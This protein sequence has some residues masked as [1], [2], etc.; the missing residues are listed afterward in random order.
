[1][2]RKSTARKTIAKRQANVAPKG[3]AQPAARPQKRKGLVPGLLGNLGDTVGSFF[4]GSALGRLGRRAGN[5]LGEIT[6]LGTYHVNRNVL[7]TSNSVPS[8]RAESNGS[9]IITHR[10]FVADI[11]GSTS[12]SDVVRSIN[13]GLSTTFPW[14][15]SIASNY[16]QYEFLGLIFEFKSTS[17]DA[18]N[19]TNTALGTV[20]MATQYDSL[21][22]PFLN[23]QQMEAYQFVTSSAPSQSM[24][25]PVECDPRQNALT[26]MY[27]RTGPA[28][29]GADLRFYDLGNMEIATVGMQATAVIG[30]LWV[31]YCVKLL[32]PKLSVNASIPAHYTLNSGLGWLDGP[33][34]RPG[35]YDHVTFSGNNTI[36]FR[37]TGRYTVCLGVRSSSMTFNNGITLG[38]GVGLV[39]SQLGLATGNVEIPNSATTNTFLSTVT[40]S[41]TA[42][43]ASITYGGPT[44]FTGT[45]LGDLWVFPTPLGLLGETVNRPLTELEQLRLRLDEMEEKYTSRDV[46]A[47]HV[48]PLELPRASHAKMFANGG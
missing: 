46:D 24:I 27:I 8:F 16:E 7:L 19:S 36:N 11:S 31:S 32:K 29:T 14:L 35:Y 3:P 30:E 38:G 5:W 15:S 13:P 9:A 21:D 39:N 42:L 33:S 25:H 20:I 40:V 12:F 23:K 18:L 1:M 34:L 28:P 48:K 10:E 26:N 44:S 17:A 37:G 41:V 43:P 2:T 45:P 4:G 22:A 47:F 6:G